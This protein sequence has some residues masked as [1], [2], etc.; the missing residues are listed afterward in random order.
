MLKTFLYQRVSCCV[1]TPTFLCHISDSTRRVSGSVMFLCHTIHSSD[2]LSHLCVIMKTFLYQKGGIGWVTM[3][4]LSNFCVLFQTLSTRRV[5][6]GER[7]GADNQN[8]HPRMHFCPC[9]R[10]HWREQNVRRC[11]LHG[12]DSF[13]TV[14]KEWSLNT[15]R[16]LKVKNSYESLRRKWH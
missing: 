15:F 16:I 9:L 4:L 12:T 10:V 1:F 6:G 2:C 13:E 8:W 5:A 7:R 3:C 11:P 14:G